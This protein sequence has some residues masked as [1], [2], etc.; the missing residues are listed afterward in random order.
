[1]KILISIICGVLAICGFVSGTY[2]ENLCENKNESVMTHFEGK[3]NYYIGTDDNWYSSNLADTQE[4]YTFTTSDNGGT[5]TISFNQSV[6]L[7]PGEQYTYSIYFY[8]GEYTF[9]PLSMY[10]NDNSGN[11]VQAS[12]RLW[13]TSQSGESV[14]WSKTFLNT[15]L[16]Y[17]KELEINTSVSPNFEANYFML[18]T[19]N[20]TPTTYEPYGL[21]YYSTDNYE[22]YG[23][24]QYTEGQNSVLN[25][26]NDYNLYTQT[27]YTEYGNGKYTEGQNSVTSGYGIDNLFLSI[28]DVPFKTLS[29]FL[30][31]PVFGTTIWVML[32]SMVTLLLVIYLIKKV[33]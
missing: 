32:G 4:S 21:K 17:V 9:T 33:I 29:N 27:Q 28:A 15:S 23:S 20:T 11:M 10:L 13:T 8:R 26:P 22:N 18:C 3:K 24:T 6:R 19:G 1:M 25:N 31:I 2:S 16:V 12:Q 5:F 14:K 30:N 7:A